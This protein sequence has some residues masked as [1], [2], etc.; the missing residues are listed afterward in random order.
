MLAS[1]RQQNLLEQYQQVRAY[2]VAICKPLAWEDYVVQPM[3]DVSPPKWHLGHVTWF[4]E[5]FILLAL[6]PGYVAFNPQFNFVFNSYYEA[7]GKRVIRTDRGNLSRPSVQEVYQYRDYVDEQ[8]SSFLRDSKIFDETLD[9]IELGLNHEQ[10]HQE[11]MLTD[12]KYILGHNPLFPVYLADKSA[13]KL[14][15]QANK[16]IE[17]KAGLYE[18][19]A[20][21]Q[22]FSYDNERNRHQVYLN[23]FRVETQLVTNQD[24]MAFIASG[25]YEDFQYWHADGWAWVKEHNAKAPLYWHP[26]DGQWMNYTLSGLSAIDTQSP[27]CHLNFYEA[28][29]F[30]AW[31]G[32]RLPTEAEWEV[33]SEQLQWGARWEWTN[34]AY[35]PYPGFQQ[36]AGAIGE[37]NGKF[38][39]NQMVLRGS[40]DVTSNGHSRKS[41]RNFFYPWQQWQYTGLRLVH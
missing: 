28:S 1:N 20:A 27:V 5:T 32:M 15:P 22:G 14:I 16:T 24:Y 7:L 6:Q 33:A 39:V 40:S 11:L 38:M 9:L 4:F 3:A 37:Y 18:I 19:G 34:S 10:Q 2:S 13:P 25:G 29:A 23:D 30:A 21:A 36:A 12:I 35:L 41:Y 8:M 17:I 31:K 26:G